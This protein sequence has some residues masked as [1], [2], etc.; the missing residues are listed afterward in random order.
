METTH[1]S[2]T[3]ETVHPRRI[4]CPVDLSDFSPLVLAHAVA[5]ARWYGAEVIALHVFA[6]WIPPA[7]EST[8]PGWMLQVRDARE[9]IE[10]E[11]QELVTPFLAAGVDVPLHRAEG[12]AAREIV[13]HAAE[14][15]A[16]LIVMGTHGRSGFDRLTLGSVA[17]KVLRKARCPVLTLPPGAPRTTEGVAFGQI[18]CPVDLSRSSEPALDLAVSLA[19]KAHGSVTALHVVE[20]LDGDQELHGYKDVAEV[21]RHQCA[22]AEQELREITTTRAADVD[23][24]NVVV[25]GRPHREI[26]R[27]A[28]E[29]GADLIVM[30]VR[31]R[32]PVDLTLFGSTTNQV[33][34][35]ATC[36]VITVRRRDEETS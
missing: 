24:A 22:T 18:L 27:I 17:E 13:R 16:D 20:A 12:D 29:R 33:V 34:R 10:R 11:L 6:A 19:A 30:G 2:S 4:L 23:V 3:Q 1:A 36:A 15:H 25:V 32:G 35:R 26:L 31:G 8:Y 14:V 9:S 7:D 21:R 5:L 28:S